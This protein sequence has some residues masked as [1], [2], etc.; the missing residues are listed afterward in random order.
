MWKTCLHP[1]IRESHRV[2]EER[3]VGGKVGDR[4]ELGY[5]RREARSD[6]KKVY[7]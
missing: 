5:E 1:F 6:D 2:G 7:I 3:K 4:E